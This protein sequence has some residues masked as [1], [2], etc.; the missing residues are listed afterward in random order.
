MRRSRFT[1]MCVDCSAIRF[2]KNFLKVETRAID[3]MLHRTRTNDAMLTHQQLKARK[4][5]AMSIADKWRLQYS[6]GKSKLVSA[7]RRID[8]GHRNCELVARGKF[9][10]V[11]VLMRRRL[12]RGARPAT[13]LRRFNE[14]IEHGFHPRGED[15]DGRE[16]FEKAFLQTCFGG[17]RNLWLSQKIDGGMGKSKLKKWLNA[18]AIP[19]FI[20]C[21]GELH[22]RTLAH[23]L[24]EFMFSTLPPTLRACHVVAVDNVNIDERLRLWGKIGDFGGVRGVGRESAAA[25]PS[26]FPR[27]FQSLVSLAGLIESDAVQLA[28]EVT[29]LALIRN[30]R[31][32]KQIVPIFASGSSCKGGDDVGAH[33]WMIETVIRM[34]YERDE[35]YVQRGP[36]STVSSDSGSTLRK[37]MRQMFHA[38]RLPKRFCDLFINCP[39]FDLAGDPEHGTTDNADDKHD[40]KNLRGGVSRKKGAL[41]GFQM[42]GFL[43]FSPVLKVDPTPRILLFTHFPPSQ[44]NLRTR[45]AFVNEAFACIRFTSHARR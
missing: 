16:D 34:W 5:Y 2:S 29:V 15:V 28:K 26:F 32:T 17:H 37:A 1:G 13:I 23:N 18:E 31:G 44:P 4:D 39:G 20:L 41:R 33:V 24:H 12:K 40:F 36:I 42:S 9:G 25:V 7:L 22:V 11:H 8:D 38:R 27:T 45:N 35:G 6:K 19:R 43:T 3:G 30:G 14:A 10:K 21:H